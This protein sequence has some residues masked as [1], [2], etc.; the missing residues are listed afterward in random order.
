MTHE[1]ILNN[2][3]KI[4]ADL[5]NW[6]LQRKRNPKKAGNKVL[7]ETIGYF[8]SLDNMV[9]ELVE[10]DIRTIEKNSLLEWVKLTADLKKLIL[11]K[12]K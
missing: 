7:W 2:I 12:I 6:I 10:Y 8:N 5:Y 9:E 3:Y 4:D 11:E 1:I